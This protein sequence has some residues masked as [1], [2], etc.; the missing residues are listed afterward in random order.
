MK[1]DSPYHIRHIQLSD[2]GSIN[3]LAAQPAR[4]YVVWWYQSLALAHMYTEPGQQIDNFYDYIWNLV[5]PALSGYLNQAEDMEMLTNAFIT[6]SPA[7]D[8]LMYDSLKHVL[9]FDIPTTV[10]LSVIICTANRPKALHACLESIFNQ[11]SLPQEVIVVDNAPASETQAACSRWQV[12]YVPE[13]RRGLSYARNTGIR[14]ATQ[15]V[16]AWTDDDV[17]VHPLWC[18]QVWQ[19]FEKNDTD[20]LLGLVIAS[21]LETE[22]QQVFEKYW[23]FNRGYLDKLYDYN[24]YGNWVPVP[25]WLFVKK[26]LTEQAILMYGLEPVHQAAAKIRKCGFES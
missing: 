14:N 25:T 4:Q 12:R 11:T 21:E 16:L 17:T 15:Q 20:A 3:D 19:A 10:P 23:S 26:C 6:S 1:K 9:H 8:S 18:W 13:P 2:F 7:F 24:W 5:S 22:S